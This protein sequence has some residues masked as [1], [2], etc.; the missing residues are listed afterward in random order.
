MRFQHVIKMICDVSSITPCYLYVRQFQL[1]YE[2]FCKQYSVPADIFKGKENVCQLCKFSSLKYDVNITI[3]YSMQWYF[4][5]CSLLV[6]MNQIQ[7]HW[8]MCVYIY[9]HICICIIFFRD[10][11]FEQCLW[12]APLIF[13]HLMYGEAVSLCKGK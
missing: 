7:D 12:C 9:I 11:Y 10:F 13:F 3:T 8:Q 4:S 5:L 1:P 2:A 6:L